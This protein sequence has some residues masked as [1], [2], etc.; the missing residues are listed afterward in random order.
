MKKQ[1]A[2]KSIISIQLHCRSPIASVESMPNIV[3]EIMSIPS[4]SKWWCDRTL[5]V[6]TAPFRTVPTARVERRH[7]LANILSTVCLSWS[8]IRNK[9]SYSIECWSSRLRLGETTGRVVENPKT[10]LV[11]YICRDMI[12]WNYNHVIH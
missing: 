7:D 6:L 5:D 11:H 12:G 3:N 10:A 2:I 1:H 8:S 4:N 9:G